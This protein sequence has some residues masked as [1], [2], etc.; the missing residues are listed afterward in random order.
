VRLWLGGDVT[1]GDDC[2]PVPLLVTIPAGAASV[3]VQL[4]PHDDALVEGPETATLVLCA[5][6]D[7]R[8]DHAAAQATATIADDDGTAAT[9]TV[10]VVAIDASAGETANPGA[11][12]FSRTGPTT[13]PL[14]VHY[15][16]AGSATRDVDLQPLPGTA[17]I[18]A[19]AQSAVLTVLPRNDTVAEASETAIVTLLADANYALGQ[20]RS[21][22]VVVADDDRP[23]LLPIVG[24]IAT[25][26]AI[27]EPAAAGAF[28]LL[29]TGSTAQPLTVRFAVGGTATAGGDYVAPA[30]VATIAAGSAWVRVPVQAIDDLAVEGRESVVLRL[31]PD[32]AYA[33]P[34]PFEP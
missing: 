21:A 24:A 26:P 33:I 12:R 2:D 7:H 16:L 20:G 3:A 5:S 29:R 11:V 17:T 27:G 31:L 32:P 13:A 28:T 34:R 15:R 18:A 9:P 8:I 19:G 14:L 23:P 4:V 10:D 30:T 22:H 6:A 1:P 25:D